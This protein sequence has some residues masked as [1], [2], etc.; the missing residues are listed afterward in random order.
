MEGLNIWLYLQGICMTVSFYQGLA[1]KGSAWVLWSWHRVDCGW[2]DHLRPDSDSYK[3]LP[4]TDSIQYNQTFTFSFPRG[5]WL[6]KQNLRSVPRVSS[7]PCEL[8]QITF[9]LPLLQRFAYLFQAP[10]GKARTWKWKYS[11]RLMHMTQRCKI[12]PTLWPTKHQ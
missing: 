9:F 12:L 8:G 5:D 3:L 6:V 7:L 4:F 2:C 10:L 1:N 11:S